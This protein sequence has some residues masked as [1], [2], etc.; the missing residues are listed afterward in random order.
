MVCVSPSWLTPH[1]M[2]KSAVREYFTLGGR[3]SPI[4]EYF[5]LGGCGSPLMTRFPM[6]RLMALMR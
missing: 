6:D 3:C 1:N 4:S 5:S 2:A